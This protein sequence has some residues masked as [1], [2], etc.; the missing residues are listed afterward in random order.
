MERIG[1]DGFVGASFTAANIK[2]KRNNF[3]IPSSLAARLRRPANFD[4]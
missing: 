3:L 1:R 4:R 2:I